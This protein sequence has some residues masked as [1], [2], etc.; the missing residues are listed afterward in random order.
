MRSCYGKQTCFLFWSYLDFPPGNMDS[1]MYHLRP[2]ICSSCKRK[3]HSFE[4][5]QHHKK[6]HKM[7]YTGA[8]HTMSA[9]LLVKRNSFQ[10]GL[11][12]DDCRSHSRTHF[13]KKQHRCASLLTTSQ[14]SASKKSTRTYTLSNQW[15][16]GEGSLLTHQSLRTRT[17]ASMKSTG[18]IQGVQGKSCPF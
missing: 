16:R 6:R 10:K 2:F 17:S 18:M 3:F 4:W 14:K 9:K 1:A 5:L 15:S 8:C 7:K 12:R 11:R 13:N